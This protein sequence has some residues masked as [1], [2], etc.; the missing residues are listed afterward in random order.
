M[1]GGGEGDKEGKIKLTT[2]DSAES[3]E[4]EDKDDDSQDDK[5]PDW[6]PSFA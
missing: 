3:K 1:S 6:K 4:N 2:S 5:A